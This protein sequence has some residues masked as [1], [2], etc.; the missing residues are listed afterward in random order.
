MAPRTASSYTGAS[1]FSG[2]EKA[3]SILTTATS[4]SNTEGEERAIE[5]AEGEIRQLLG[6]PKVGER[7]KFSKSTDSF[8]SSISA[9]PTV[10]LVSPQNQDNSSSYTNVTSANIVTST[11][12]TGDQFGTST[13]EARLMSD[14]D[15]MPTVRVDYG[16]GI[17]PSTQPTSTAQPNYSR[18][19]YF[20]QR[21]AGGNALFPSLQSLPA[22]SRYN[23]SYLSPTQPSNLYPEQS[24]DPTQRQCHDSSPTKQITITEAISPTS[25]QS[26]TTKPLGTSGSVASVRKVK[27]SRR[28][29]TVP[30][31]YA[32]PHTIQSTY[33]A[34]STPPAGLS[35]RPLSFALSP[36][37]K[38][39]ILSM[40]NF[41]GLDN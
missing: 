31:P 28:P 37:T 41:D 15:S 9:I 16:N 40:V 13:P 26:P 29:S 38:A 30:Q 33:F 32:H 10:S 18:H 17:S 12:S 35:N 2:S 20:P 8:N 11:T 3:R 23:N 25:S 36:H 14:T 24:Q 6:Q 27:T 5:S 7:L 19:S 1:A 34:T 4:P 39:G 22:L 21:M